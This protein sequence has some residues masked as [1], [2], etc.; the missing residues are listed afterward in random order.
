MKASELLKPRQPPEQ[1]LIDLEGQYILTEMGV[2]YCVTRSIPMRE[3]RSSR[4]LIETGF[5][6]TRFNPF[7]VQRFVA[8]ALLAG[9]DIQ[10][11]ELVSKRDEIMRVTQSLIYGI[12][13]KKLRPH[14]KQLLRENPVVAQVIKK[15]AGPRGALQVIN[16]TVVAR[17]MSDHRSHVDAIRDDLLREATESLAAS[18]DMNLE[19]SQEDVQNVTRLVDA[20]DDETWFL[21]ALLRTGREREKML[22]TVRTT[23]LSY[24]E[25]TRISDYVSLLLMEFVEQGEQAHFL[26]LA[27][28]DRHARG[29]Q[30]SI[31][32]L[33]SDPAF[34]RRLLDRAIENGD[35]LTLSYRFEGNPHDVTSKTRLTISVTNRGL[36]GYGSRSRLMGRRN[37]NVRRSSLADFYRETGDGSPDVGALYLQYLEAACEKEGVGLE[38]ALLRDERKE[39]TMISLILQ[40]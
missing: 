27:E 29:P 38:T 19:S 17:F 25:Q 23:I 18:R 4:G 2:K 40:L 31:Q 22:E 3:F 16:P 8:H 20:V 39:E 14:L 34:R 6:W 33:L 1:Q 15:A 28:H 12:L 13:L 10:R 24:A 11:P 21:L 9:I 30:V 7:V 26:N 36:V 37:R 35:L 5:R 32:Q